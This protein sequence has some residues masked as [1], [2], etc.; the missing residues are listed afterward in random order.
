MESTD[1]INIPDKLLTAKNTDQIL[2]LCQEFTCNLGF[3]YFLFGLCTPSLSLHTPD[4]RIISNYPETWMQIY[5]DQGLIAVDPV[6]KYCQEHTL[7]VVWSKLNENTKYNNPKYLATMKA[8]EK[9]GLKSG[10]SVPLRSP[11][12]EFGIFSVSKNESGPQVDQECK[13]AIAKTQYLANHAMEALLA[14]TESKR[15]REA[16]ALREKLT[17]REYECLFWACEGKTAWEISVIL[18]IT[19]RTV[20]FHLSNATIKMGATNRQHAV[21][22]ALLHGIIKPNLV[23]T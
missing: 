11:S 22:K 21:A 18:K 7:P 14:I 13:N 23:S 12:G 2:E 8:A 6:V 16:E 17:R 1:Y 4:I 5:N 20:L 9:H 3:D 15:Q 19:E 10:I